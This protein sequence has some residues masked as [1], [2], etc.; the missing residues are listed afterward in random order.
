MNR[1]ETDEKIPA[2]SLFLKMEQ[3]K[4]ERALRLLPRVLKPDETP[5]SGEWREHNA[6]IP[7]HRACSR[8][9]LRARHNRARPAGRDFLM[10]YTHTHHLECGGVE[11]NVPLR[12]MR[13]PDNVGSPAFG[14]TK[15]CPATTPSRIKDA[16]KQSMVHAVVVPSV[17][18]LLLLPPSRV[19]R[20]FLLL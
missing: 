15:A 1:A 14:A 12:A 20:T 5:S 11:K 10:L 17:D 4:K 16:L 6:P 8:G 13:P 18:S 3:S 9:C 19:S 7:D 2:T